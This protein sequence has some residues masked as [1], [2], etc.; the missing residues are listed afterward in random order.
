MSLLLVGPKGSF[1]TRWIAY[2]VLRDNVQ[3]H[4]ESG[5]PSAS[6][7]ALHAISEAL[8]GGVTS[9]SATELRGCAEQARAKLASLPVD[10]L[11]VSNRTIAALALQPP[12][13]ER[14]TQLARESG[15]RI[16]FLGGTIRTFEDA[17]GALI[18]SIL[19]ITEGARA[20]DRVEV[21]DL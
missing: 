8:G 2:A 15:V 11:A 10:E 18:D 7:R 17:C 3:H 16:P 4:L 6:F 20:S 21:S 12:P 14:A 5:R 1:E 19:S 13:G 9:V